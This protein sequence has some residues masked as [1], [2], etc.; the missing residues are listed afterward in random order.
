MQLTRR[1]AV[2]GAGAAAVAAIGAVAGTTAA[3]AAA[4]PHAASASTAAASA[5]VRPAATAASTTD[6]AEL[7]AAVRSDFTPLVGRP[8]SAFGPDE[9]VSSLVLD[10][11][12]DVAGAPAGDENRFALHFR[13]GDDF[14]EG[15]WE[16]GHDGAP[17]SGFLL[18]PIGP[19]GDRRAQ[20]VVNRI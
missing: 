11:V 13:A 10:E 9:A 20:A 6:F 19:A 18:T 17:L 2:A 1:T 7:R 5:A 16:L 4:G 12:V 14:V 8:I 15:I 3:S